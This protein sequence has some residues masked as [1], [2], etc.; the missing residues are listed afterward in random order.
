VRVPIAEEAHPQP[1]ATSRARC[2]AADHIRIAVRPRPAR[3]FADQFVQFAELPRRCVVHRPRTSS[4][5]IA[6]AE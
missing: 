3:E 1:D 2:E 5:S 6:A 4:N